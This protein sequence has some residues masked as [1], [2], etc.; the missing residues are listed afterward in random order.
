METHD[1]LLLILER[2]L[3]I[4]ILWVENRSHQLH[5]QWCV[6]SQKKGYETIATQTTRVQTNIWAEEKWYSNWG[7]T[8][9]ISTAVF[10]SRILTKFQENQRSKQKLLPPMVSPANHQ[11]LNQIFSS[12]ICHQKI[13]Q[14]GSW[15]THSLIPVMLKLFVVFLYLKVSLAEYRI[16]ASLFSRLSLM[17]FSIVSG[18]KPCGQGPMSDFLSFKNDLVFLPGCPKRLF[19]P[20]WALCYQNMYWYCPFWA[21]VP[22]MLYSLS[23]GRFQNFSQEGFL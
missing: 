18:L 17:Y 1:F 9:L 23:V 8:E 20:L 4:D 21:N 16:I 10:G 14:E 6:A 22:N 12:H 15:E 2:D 13:S 3:I 5:M 19:F 11:P 7:T